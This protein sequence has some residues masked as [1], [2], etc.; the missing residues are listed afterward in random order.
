MELSKSFYED[1]SEKF[2]NDEKNKLAR[3]AV[4]STKLDDII[5]NRELI[6]QHNRYIFEF[7]KNK[8]ITIKS[9]KVWKMLVICTL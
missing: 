2:N 7:Y 1:A 8:N 5:V 6:Q 9:K 4:T 3:N